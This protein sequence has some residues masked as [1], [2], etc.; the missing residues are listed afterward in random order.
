MAGQN[1]NGQC[2]VELALVMMVMLALILA[3]H[4]LAGDTKNYVTPASHSREMKR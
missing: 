2:G 4:H 1:S 3:I